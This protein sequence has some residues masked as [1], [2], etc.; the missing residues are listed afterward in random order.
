M[1]IRKTGGRTRKNRFNAVNG[2]M[3]VEGASVKGK[4]VLLLDDLRTSGMS[5]LEATKILKNA[6]VED[7]VYL[8]FGTH[9]NKVPLAREI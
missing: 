6:G 9:T 5:I 3:I 8:C 2:T 4:K 7:V 1:N